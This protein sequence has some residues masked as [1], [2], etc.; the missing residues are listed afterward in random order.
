MAI[1]PKTV[2]TMRLGGE[3]VSHSRTRIDEEWIVERP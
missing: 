1:K 3:C 2:V